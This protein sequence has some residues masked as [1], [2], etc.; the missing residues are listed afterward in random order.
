[1]APGPIALTPG[2][3]AHYLFLPTGEGNRA[4]FRPGL[5][6]RGERGYIVAPPSIHP[7]GGVYEWVFDADTPLAP[8]PP[9]LINLVAGKETQSA[10]NREHSGRGST[11][12]QAALEREVGKVAL[13]T[14]GKRNDTLNRAAYSLGQLVGGGHLDAVV[15]AEALLEVSL[16]IGLGRD[17]ATATILSG[18]DAGIRRPRSVAA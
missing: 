8:A 11:Y 16:R 13:A 1:M 15:T 6:W 2:G 17:E 18:M 5:D 9:W 10:A 12:G 7:S 14:E 3:G 4:G